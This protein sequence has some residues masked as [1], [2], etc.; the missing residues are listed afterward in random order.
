MLSPLSRGLFH[1]AIIQSALPLPH[2]NVSHA[3]IKRGESLSKSLNCFGIKEELK[4]LRQISPEEIISK[5]IKFSIIED[6]NFSYNEDLMPINDGINLISNDVI[7]QLKSGNFHKVPVIIGSTLNESNLFT[8]K[9]LAVF[10]TENFYKKILNSTYGPAI[11]QKLLK[12]YPPIPSA[13]HALDRLLTHALFSCPSGTMAK[14]LSKF[15][16]TY[17][18]E[19]WYVPSFSVSFL[20]ACHG[21]ELYFLFGNDSPAG[22]ALSPE[23]RIVSNLMI[24]YWSQFAYGEEFS[25]WPKI[26][27][28]KH[29]IKKIDLNIDNIIPV[30]YCELWENVTTMFPFLHSSQWPF[31]E[32]FINTLAL[33][34]LIYSIGN[35]KAVVVIITT[36]LLLIIVLVSCCCKKRYKKTKEKTT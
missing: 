27:Q 9:D 22:G 21:S 29:L 16:P 36:C 14:I 34:I 25:D 30:Q 32:T 15:V 11:T 20:G 19:F 6:E 3:A 17:Q 7:E 31:I 23:D 5:L 24:K 28:T 12:H 33:K 26:T 2:I 10:A 8:T 13:R 18:Y 1:R 35:M 4:C